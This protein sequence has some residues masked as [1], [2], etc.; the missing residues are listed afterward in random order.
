MAQTV[1]YRNGRY[2]GC[3]TEDR[4]RHG[5]GMLISDESEVLLGS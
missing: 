4:K 5:F 1:S 3:C 2:Q